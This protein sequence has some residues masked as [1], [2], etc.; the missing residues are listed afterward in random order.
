MVNH[1]HIVVGHGVPEGSV[2]GPF[3]IGSNI[4][5]QSSIQFGCYADDTQLNVT[6]QLSLKYNIFQY[7]SDEKTKLY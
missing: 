2:L 1:P 3:A 4:I 6:G 7:L 5:S